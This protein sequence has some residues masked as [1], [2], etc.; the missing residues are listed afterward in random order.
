M[1]QDMAQIDRDMALIASERKR[2]LAR[3]RWTVRLF[4]LLALLVAA[5]PWLRRWLHL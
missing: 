4:V 5:W 1:S 2:Q 3:F